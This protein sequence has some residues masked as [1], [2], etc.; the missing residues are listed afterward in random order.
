MA[1]QGANNPDNQDVADLLAAVQT[2]LQTLTGAVQALQQQ[3]TALT[4]LTQD[5]QNE[6]NAPTAFHLS[7]AQYH[8]TEIVNI[9]SRTGKAVFDLVQAGLAT[10]YDL[11]RDGWPAFIESMLEAVELLACDTENYSVVDYTPTGAAG[12]VNIIDHFGEVTVDE[13]K[14]QSALFMTGARRNTRHGQNNMFMCQFTL[15]SLT[16]DAKQ[17]VMTYKK[18]FMMTVN[19]KDQMNFALLWK[20]IAKIPSL[21]SKAT[22]RI[23]RAELRA[24]G[25]QINE[26]GIPKFNI[27]FKSKMD[28]LTA[29]GETVDDPVQMLLEAYLKAGDSRFVD[30][31][32]IKKNEL[33]DD[34]GHFYGKTWEEILDKGLVKYNGWSDDWGKKTQAEE[35]FL[36][37][38]AN[39]LRG[40]ST[41]GALSALRG[42]LELKGASKGS[43]KPKPKAKANPPANASSSSSKVSAPTPKKNKKPMADRRRQKKDE[44]WKKVPPKAGDPLTKTVDGWKCYWCEHHMAWCGHPSSDCLLGKRRIE[45]QQQRSYKA[46]TATTPASSA[47]TDPA[48]Q[49]QMEFMAKLAGLSNMNSRLE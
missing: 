6:R 15:N 33:D 43:T 11:G 19:G 49:H 2:G 46:A 37:L 40:Q 14:A 21:D 18:K 4:T 35:T 25:D 47:S 44:A 16:P 5:I 48:V 27:A 22:A 29:R 41:S 30:Y 31:I 28:A 39:L 42:Q 36:A 3:S 8:P 38:A 24:L 20:A 34:E 1:D 17:T 10:K 13:I 7:P 12:P 45:E 26:L 23:L 32:T 9:A